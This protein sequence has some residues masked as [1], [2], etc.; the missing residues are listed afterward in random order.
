MRTTRSLRSCCSGSGIR[1]VSG[2][3]RWLGVWGVV[4]LQI[5]DEDGSALDGAPSRWRTLC[6]EGTVKDI[7]MFVRAHADLIMRKPGALYGGYPMFVDGTVMRFGILTLT[8]SHR[9]I[10]PHA[11]YTNTRDTHEGDAP[12]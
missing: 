9:H 7:E 11:P 8:V 2:L 10:H 4:T 5:T 12:R 1:G 6:V 3:L